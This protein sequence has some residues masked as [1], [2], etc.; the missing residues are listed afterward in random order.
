MQLSH[1]YP[2]RYR[3]VFDDFSIP[4]ESFSVWTTNKAAVLYES[5]EELVEFQNAFQMLTEVYMLSN[6]KQYRAI[7]E[8]Y[9]PQVKS[10][11]LSCFTQWHS[12]D[13]EI[14]P[15]LRQFSATGMYLRALNECLTALEKARMHQAYVDEVKEQLTFQTTYGH[16]YRAHW[17]IRAALISQT[18]LK[19][20]KLA[21]QFCRTGLQDCFVRFGNRIELYSRL[22]KIDKSV[23]EQD[24]CP[25]Y[26][27]LNYNENTIYADYRNIDNDTTRKNFFFITH[28]NGDEELLSVEEIVIHHYKQ[29]GFP[30]GIHCE[31]SIYHTFFALLFWDLLYSVDYPD[32]F[33]FFKQLGP[34]DLS[35]DCFYESRKELID[36]RILQISNFTTERL[37][38]ELSTS[39]LNHC[40]KASFLAHWDL[41]SLENLIVVFHSDVF[42]SLTD[43][44]SFAGNRNLSHCR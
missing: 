37:K 43:T 11:F 3:V 10:S 19:D 1:D 29:N 4:R 5:H 2:F 27:L 23:K 32:T 41:T 6:E 22:V 13:L 30:N 26:Y 24:L 17:Y 9:Y 7:T 12:K 18:H 14:A 20:A 21:E 31:S 42:C 33:R 28:Q 8:K 39:W 38:D 25:E 44:S 34:L 40:N 35:F 15:F 16:K 36:E